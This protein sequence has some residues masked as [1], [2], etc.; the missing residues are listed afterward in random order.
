MWMEAGARRPKQ[1]SM[2]SIRQVSHKPTPTPE[3]E[4]KGALP[5]VR[6][7]LSGVAAVAEP[8]QGDNATL[9]LGSSL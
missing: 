5:C 8:R 3:R 9:A 1:V 2:G 6:R 7:R 4:S